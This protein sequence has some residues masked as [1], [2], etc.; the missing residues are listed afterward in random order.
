MKGKCD[1]CGNYC[2]NL[3][4]MQEC[5]LCE[6]YRWSQTE[7]CDPCDLCGKR[8]WNEDIAEGRENTQHTSDSELDDWKELLGG[9]REGE[10][11]W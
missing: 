11:D 7:P 8:G 1:Q 6:P 4:E 9:E 5:C 2:N 3:S 10:V